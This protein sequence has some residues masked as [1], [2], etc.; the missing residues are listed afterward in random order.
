MTP[1]AVTGESVMRQFLPAVTPSAVIGEDN[2][3]LFSSSNGS[4]LAGAGRSSGLDPTIPC[5]SS[6]GSLASSRSGVRGSVD[7]DRAC[8]ARWLRAGAARSE[9]G[10]SSM[11]SDR[12]WCSWQFWCCSSWCSSMLTMVFVTPSIVHSRCVIR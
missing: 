3:A 12:K 2:V 4:S 1:I 11:A 7:V 6:A 10:E 9:V 5:S 8:A